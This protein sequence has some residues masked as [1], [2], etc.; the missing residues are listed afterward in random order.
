MFS[1]PV[2]FRAVGE[3]GAG[4]AIAPP[5]FWKFCLFCN[6]F[7][8]QNAQIRVILSD[9]PPSFCIAPPLFNKLQWPCFDYNLTTHYKFEGQGQQNKIF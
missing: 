2:L 5:V 1:V 8:P 6:K 7:T 3:R 4:R 9:S